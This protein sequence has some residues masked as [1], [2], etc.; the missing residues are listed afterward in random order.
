MRPSN[1]GQINGEGL[2]DYFISRLLGIL[3][4]R[5]FLNPE[6]GFP[7]PE[8]ELGAGATLRE[9]KSIVG[10]LGKSRTPTDRYFSILALPGHVAFCACVIGKIPGRE[11]ARSSAPACSSIVFVCPP[12]APHSAA[13]AALTV[14]AF[15]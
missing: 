1:P 9:A 5:A 3:R 13:H 12:P 8:N 14:D 11:R 7:G 10:A 15:A 6:G 4:L 2:R